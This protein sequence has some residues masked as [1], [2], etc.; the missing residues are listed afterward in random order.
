MVKAAA[1]GKTVIVY[2][3]GSEPTWRGVAGLKVLSSP[4]HFLAQAMEGGF[5]RMVV[6][7][8]WSTSREKETLL[9]LCAVLRTSPRTREL[10]LCCILQEPHREFLASLA[11][12]E[13]TWVRFLVAD[14]PV[15]PSLLTPPENGGQGW[16]RMAEVLRVM[17][18]H[19][20][21]H[22]VTGGGEMCVC[23]AYRNRMVL[24]QRTLR[25]QCQAARHN[26]CPYFLDP[27]PPAAS[28]GRGA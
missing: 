17:C 25:E 7:L 10:P 13:V 9:E 16:L 12:A 15:L 22:P 23:G 27:H 28:V 6:F 19:L 18:P 20:N 24:G 4:L 5:G 2:R 8:E 11:Q 14:Q 26:Q 1:A 3:R 21:Y